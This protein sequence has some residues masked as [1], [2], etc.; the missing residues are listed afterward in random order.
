[1]DWFKPDYF[2]FLLFA[3]G[4][5]YVVFQ[6]VTRGGV[7]NAMFGGKVKKTYGE[8]LLRKQLGSTGKL[9]VHSVE[10][11]EGGKVGIEL[12]QK[13]FLSFSVIPITLGKPEAL[14]LIQMLTNVTNEA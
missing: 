11:K 6:I 5:T 12:S 4:A 3:F 8:I 13:G 7:R 10:T 14:Q 9:K 1:M 2:P